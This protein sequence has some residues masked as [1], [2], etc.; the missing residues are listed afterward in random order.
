MV[1]TTHVMESYKVFLE[2][3]YP[4]HYQSYCNRL[5]S[6]PEA[7]RAEAITF[8]LLRS[9]FDEVKLSE[10]IGK[11]GADFFILRSNMRETVGARMS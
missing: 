2:V 5:R 10:D 9:I 4:T 11:G 6:D 8:S 3:K 7:A 1:S